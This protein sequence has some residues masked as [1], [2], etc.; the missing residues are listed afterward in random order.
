MFRLNTALQERPLTDRNAMQLL[1][2]SIWFHA[3]AVLPHTPNIKL[4]PLCVPMR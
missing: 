2:F 4:V 3:R 1:K